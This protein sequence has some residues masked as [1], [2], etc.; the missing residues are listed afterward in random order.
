[1]KKDLCAGGAA[2][3][4]IQH[5]SISF[6]HECR[7][8]HHSE[9][10]PLSSGAEATALS[11]S[12]ESAREVLFGALEAVDQRPPPPEEADHS[13]E[14]SIIIIRWLNILCGAEVLYARGSYTVH[15]CETLKQSTHVIHITHFIYTV[16]ISST[17]FLHVVYTALQGVGRES[18]L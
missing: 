18:G 14:H 16:Y 15:A 7:R 2:R 13:L 5:V 17:Y 1:M 3:R 12:S 10:S 4:R 6:R 11:V 8:R 9:W